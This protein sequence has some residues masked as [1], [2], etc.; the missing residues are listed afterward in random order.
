MSVHEIVD[1]YPVLRVFIKKSQK[2]PARE[3]RMAEDRM[4]DYE[5]RTER[6]TS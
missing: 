5:R 2:I 1:T 3:S 6:S 4:A